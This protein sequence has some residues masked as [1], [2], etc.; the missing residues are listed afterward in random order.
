MEIPH[1]QLAD[2]VLRAVIEEYIT[3]EGTDYGEREYTLD[4]KVEQIINQLRHGEVLI[5]YDP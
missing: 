1:A 5:N 2:D 3:R 4:E